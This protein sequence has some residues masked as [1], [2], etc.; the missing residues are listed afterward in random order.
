MGKTTTTFELPTVCVCV[1]GLPRDSL[2]HL[3]YIYRIIS[4]IRFANTIFSWMWLQGWFWSQ[5]KIGKSLFFHNI[6]KSE[7]KEKTILR[8]DENKKD[9]IIYIKRKYIKIKYFFKKT[10]KARE[11]NKLLKLNFPFLFVGFLYVGHRWRNIKV[12]KCNEHYMEKM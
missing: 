4:N 11:M 3:R 12:L 1:C 8:K 5:E 9:K 7:I 2:E 10:F 6:Y